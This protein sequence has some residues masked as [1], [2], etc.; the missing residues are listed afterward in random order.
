MLYFT[1][2]YGEATTI[3]FGLR[4]PDGVALKTDAVC[5]DGDVVIMKDEGAEGNVD[6]DFAD[7]GKGYS[8]AFTSAEMTAA[9]IQGYIEDQGTPAWLGREFLIETYGNASAQFPFMNEGL[10]DRVLTSAT[11][12]IAKSWGKRIRGIEEYQGYEGGKIYIDTTGGGEAG[13]DPYVN[14]VLDKAVDNLAD[15]LLLSASVGINCFEVSSGSSLTFVSSQDGKCYMGNNWNLALGGQSINGIYVHGAAISGIATAAST[16]PKLEDCSLNGVT[17]PPG[18]YVAC[19]L[20]SNILAGAI[21]SYF[22][23]DCESDLAGDYPAFDFNAAIG[24]VN[25]IFREYRGE[26][27]YKNMG[28]SGTDIASIDGNGRVKM[29][30]NSIGGTIS[31]Q[32]HQELVNRAAFIAAGGIV[33]DASRFAAD[34]LVTHIIGIDGDTLE[35]LSDQIDALPT[36]VL[37]ANVVI[38]ERVDTLLDINKSQDLTI[39][40]TTRLEYQW[41]D[42]DGDAVNVTGL[43]FKFKAV[44]NAKESSPAI[45]EVTGTIQDAVNGRWYFDIL[46]TTV[47]KGR[48]EIWAVDGASKITPLTMA[49]G[50]RIETHPRL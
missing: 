18:H 30:A 14:G 40:V 41:L 29:N 44:K 4:D 42:I 50:A 1:R 23:T 13:S 10:A 26:I 12:N 36:E 20:T 3:T 43:T 15:A 9:R 31:V 47:F 2:K 37:I 6:A 7:E 22:F 8:L 38:S 48:Y 34:Q 19:G 33:N 21:G 27:E 35:A 45:A 32:G 46:P 39:D 17:L 5:V 25:A 28:Q 24:N 49:G 11:H 16:P